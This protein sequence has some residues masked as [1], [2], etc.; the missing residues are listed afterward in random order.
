VSCGCFG[1]YGTDA[2]DVLN[3]LA[4]T[5]KPVNPKRRSNTQGHIRLNWG[6]SCRFLYV[7]YLLAYFAQ[8]PYQQLSLPTYL[9][10][11]PVGRRFL[12]PQTGPLRKERHTVHLHPLVTHPTHTNI[13]DCARGSLFSQLPHAQWRESIGGDNG[14]FAISCMADLLG[15][16]RE[17]SLRDVPCA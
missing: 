12:C 2:L 4:P 14:E 6:L 1:D 9:S 3:V 5:C 17:T 11:A 8:R 7:L 10:A 15:R 16:G 13:A